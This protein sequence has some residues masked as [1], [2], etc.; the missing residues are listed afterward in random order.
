M[1]RN[2]IIAKAKDILIESRELNRVLNSTRLVRV[3]V[4]PA[5]SVTLQPNS[6]PT[7]DASAAIVTFTLED[8]PLFGLRLIVEYEGQKELAA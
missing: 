8:A 3:A 6:E 1:D 7:S 5:V 4:P 2:Q